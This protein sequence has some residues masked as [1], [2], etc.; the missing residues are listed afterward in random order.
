MSSASSS[1]NGDDE[2]ERKAP[3][4]S[5]EFLLHVVKQ[6]N[7][8]FQ[9]SLTKVGLF[10]VCS[11][12]VCLFLCLRAYGCMVC[13]SHCLVCI[14]YCVCVSFTAACV[15]A[16]CTVCMACAAGNAR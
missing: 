7:Q 13:S 15:P 4:P 8:T 14:S 1:N 11:W 16:H 10:C 2:S 5:A 6:I 12:M 3:P 9:A